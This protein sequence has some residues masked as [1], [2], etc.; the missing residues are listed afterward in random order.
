MAYILNKGLEERQEEFFVENASEISKL[1]T[2]TSEGDK[3]AA[4][5]KAYR[6]VA[7][8]SKALVIPTGEIY[9]L[10][11]SNTWDKFGG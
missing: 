6:K 11:T 3:T 4:Y 1:P 10:T 8:G 2:M 9:I 5:G 7:A